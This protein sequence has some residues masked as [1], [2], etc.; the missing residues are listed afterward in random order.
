[1]A[2][3][4]EASIAVKDNSVIVCGS[5]NAQLRLITMT[6]AIVATCHD[7]ALDISNAESG[8]YIAIAT[9]D[10]GKTISKKIA[11]R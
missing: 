3:E 5:E 8:I 6:G 1:M 11:I 9:L 4:T 10:N 7:N 2:Q